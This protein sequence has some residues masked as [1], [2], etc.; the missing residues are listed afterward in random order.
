MF[1]SRAPGRL[2]LR[3]LP[4]RRSLSGQRMRLRSKVCR[5]PLHRQERTGLQ[6]RRR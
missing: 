5:L 6:V 4:R 3:R 2:R 1:R